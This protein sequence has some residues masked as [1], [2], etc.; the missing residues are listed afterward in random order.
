[1]RVSMAVVRTYVPVYCQLSST[2]E[3]GRLQTSIYDGISS[4]KLIRGKILRERVV[5][6]P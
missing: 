3:L 5:Q 1:M 2:P 4:S 6:I